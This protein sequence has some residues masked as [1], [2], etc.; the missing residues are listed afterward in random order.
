MNSTNLPGPVS[1][2]PPLSAIV[3]PSVSRRYRRGAQF[4]HQGFGSVRA[5]LRGAIHIALE[6]VAAM[7]AGEEQ[8]ADGQSLGAGDRRPLAW[9]V[10]GVGAL[11]PCE[12]RPMEPRH[13]AIPRL[14]GAWVSAFDPAHQSRR[15]FFGGALPRGVC[16]L[17]ARVER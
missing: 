7:L 2:K 6:I 14:G 9:L 10:A 11:G 15:G 16:Q 13:L 12:G 17:A 1:R 5:R 4:R 3:T 8:V